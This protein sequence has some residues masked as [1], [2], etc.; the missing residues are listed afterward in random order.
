MIHIHET[1]SERQATHGDFATHA[2]IAQSIKCQ[3]FNA[4]GY[5]ALSAMQREA[6]DMIAHKIARILNGNPDVHD[7][8]HDIGGYATLVANTM[9]PK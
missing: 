5:V 9:E 6:L 4:H 2:L 7:H 3:M 1:L 8:W